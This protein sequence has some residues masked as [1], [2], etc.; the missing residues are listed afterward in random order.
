[1][2]R[3][4]TQAPDARRTGKRFPLELPIKILKKGSAA[5]GKTANVSAAGVY[6]QAQADLEVGA[7]IVRDYPVYDF[8]TEVRLNLT[9]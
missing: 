3:K 2:P 1:M 7:P 5:E 4:K 9:Y 8:K 6:I